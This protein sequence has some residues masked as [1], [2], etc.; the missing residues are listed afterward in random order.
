MDEIL[1]IF[2]QNC[3]NENCPELP[4]LPLSELD[5]SKY[6]SKLSFII[7][8]DTSNKNPE[9]KEN[10]ISDIL[11]WALFANRKKLAEICWLRS[12]N[13]LC[14]C[15]VSL[16]QETALSFTSSFFLCKFFEQIHP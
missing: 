1:D 3:R 6:V 10:I 13:H 8:E 2:V 5:I 4:G 9:N 11:L 15:I 14:K 16:I 12:K 7:T